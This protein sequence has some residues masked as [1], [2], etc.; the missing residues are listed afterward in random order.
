MLAHILFMLPRRSAVSTT[1]H[2]GGGA[3]HCSF[4]NIFMPSSNAPVTLEFKYCL[5]GAPCAGA[6]SGIFGPDSGCTEAALEPGFEVVGSSL[7]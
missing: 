5:A 1:L 7:G 3:T 6:F 4:A 2:Q